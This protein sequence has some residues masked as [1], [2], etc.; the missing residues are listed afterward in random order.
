M[1]TG[2]LGG[3]V[4]MRCMYACLLTNAKGKPFTSH[5]EEKTQRECGITDSLYHKGP[6]VDNK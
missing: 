4:V 1:R 3:W 2:G 5:R 6:E